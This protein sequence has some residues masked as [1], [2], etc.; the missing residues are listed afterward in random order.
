MPSFLDS[1]SIFFIIIMGYKG[2]KKGLIEEFGR[3]LS[4]IFAVFLFNV[5]KHISF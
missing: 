4:L 2:Y 1:L 5:K 3:T